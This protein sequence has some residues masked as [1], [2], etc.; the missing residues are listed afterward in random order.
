RA[1]FDDLTIVILLLNSL[2]NLFITVDFPVRNGYFCNEKI[3]L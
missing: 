2:D 3:T 1:F